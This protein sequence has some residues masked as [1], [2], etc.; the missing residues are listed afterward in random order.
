M[1]LYSDS[2]NACSHNNYAKHPTGVV[3]MY[4]VK[5]TQYVVMNLVMNVVKMFLFLH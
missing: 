5:K 4:A 2:V 1:R 3:N